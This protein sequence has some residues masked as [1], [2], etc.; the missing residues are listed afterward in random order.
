MK[1]HQIDRRWIFLFILLG[2]MIPLFIPFGLP[3]EVSNNVRR[4]YDLI[5][6]INTGERI[7]ISFDYDPASKPELQPAAVAIIK[8]AIEK[9]LRIVVIAL[10][11]MGV[12]LADEIYNAHD[13][14]LVYGQNFINLG[15]KAGGLVAIQAMGKD[16]REVFPRD[17]NGN[18]IDGFSIMDGVRNF[19][20]FSVVVS[21]SA[22]VPG[23][24]EWIMVAGDNFRLPVTGATTAVS[25]PGFLPY[26]NDQNQLH[27]IIGG[28][29]AAAEYELLIGE[30]AVATSG[31]D[32]Q[33]I[34]HIIII[35]FIIIGNISWH[36]TYRKKGKGMQN[37]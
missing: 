20:D 11:P 35:I 23:M 1:L 7:L 25:T 30:P 4:V 31:M 10:W 3:L 5:D 36:L 33:S 29:K 18:H 14:Y 34:A 8:H 37:K 19:S 16:F 27:G 21:L 6:D 22:G 2:V 28:L 26:I 15:Y 17:N 9:D 13:Q 32:A 12:S 24:R